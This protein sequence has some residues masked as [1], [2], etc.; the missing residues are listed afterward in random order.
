[1]RPR[2]LTGDMVSLHARDGSTKI[3]TALIVS[4]KQANNVPDAVLRGLDG[5]YP[6]HY[7]VFTSTWEFAYGAPRVMGPFLESQITACPA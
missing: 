2:F 3:P 7:Y 4:V 1:M 5:V 6:W